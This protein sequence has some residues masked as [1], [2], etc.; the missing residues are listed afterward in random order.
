MQKKAHLR[1][2]F[3]KLKIDGILITDIINVR[4]LTGFSGSS[5]YVVITEKNAMFV[6]DFRYEEQAGQEVKGFTIKIEHTE[7]AREIKDI[8][9]LYGIKKI[10]FEDHHVTYGFHRKLVRR[11][12]KLKPVTN[13][14]ESLRV[15]KSVREVSLIRT[16]VKRAERAFRKLQPHIMAGITEQK[17]ALKFE[18]LLKQEGCKTLPFEVIVAS[19]SMSALPHA[20][21]SNR[22]LRK[23]DLVVFDWGGECDGYCSDMSRTVLLKGRDITRQKEIY[24][25]VLEAQK[26]A[27]GAV[28]SGINASVI[29]AAAR[30]YIELQGYGEHFGHGTGHGVG[31][32]VH[33]R[34]IVSWRNKELINEN[35]VFT[36]EPGIYLPGF[37]G[38]RIEDM[39]IAGKNKAEL[40]TSLPKKLKIIEG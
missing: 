22:K 31:L 11:K 33:E 7:R 5:G 20:K 9:D 37:G 13:V 23:G 28:R 17:L 26:R 40:L 4:Y 32:A 29:D 25:N 3:Q 35:M 12:V 6:T 24:Y 21:P 2:Q 19:G 39:V 18:E 27:I 34:P 36:V 1:R 14:I 8:C 38:V 16:A 10:G 15:I 30:D